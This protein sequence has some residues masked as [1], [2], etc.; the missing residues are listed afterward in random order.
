MFH[1]LQTGIRWKGLSPQE[2]RPFV[3]EAER[4][5]VQHM[6]DHPNYKYRPRRRK[7]GKRAPRGQGGRS[8]GSGSMGS[9]MDSMDSPVGQGSVLFNQ[10]NNSGHVPDSPSPSSVDK[11]GGP[12]PLNSFRSDDQGSSS[13]PRPHLTP[14]N[15]PSY[16]FH[17]GNPVP[18]DGYLYRE[19]PRIIDEGNA[20]SL[21]DHQLSTGYPD[22]EHRVYY[23]PPQNSWE[24]VHYTDSP[25]GYDSHGQH[26]QNSG[27]SN[28]YSDCCTP[29]GYSSLDYATEGG[30]LPSDKLV[31]D[32]ESVNNDSSGRW[33]SV[34]PHHS[35]DHHHLHASSAVLQNGSSE[36]HEP[37]ARAPVE[38]DYVVTSLD[39]R[40]VQDAS[41]SYNQTYWPQTERRFTGNYS[42]V[43]QEPMVSE[44]SIGSNGSSNSVSSSASSPNN[45]NQTMS[46]NSQQ[47]LNP[48][49][50]LTSMTSS[51]VSSS[52][53]T[54]S[55]SSTTSSN[56]NHHSNNP[57]IISN[58]TLIKNPTS[59]S[60][61]YKNWFMKWAVYTSF[62]SSIPISYI[63]DVFAA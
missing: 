57:N 11:R 10:L 22:G 49:A 21:R 14:V 50:S 45:N 61:R 27:I 31:R 38:D 12:S 52:S 28:Y 35:L 53:S 47:H 34:P 4:L 2:R 33:I 59:A 7:N 56:N 5:R 24:S 17:D 9:N 26:Y 23:A 63:V 51:M 43:I 25:V 39:D 16:Y 15:P 29:K 55:P 18:P 13:S 60:F 20:G 58:N 19:M 40:K 1:V 32:Y 6:Q 30:L 37:E 44:N 41:I 62:V 48:L 46:S 3:E 42:S 8:N 54:P 36:S